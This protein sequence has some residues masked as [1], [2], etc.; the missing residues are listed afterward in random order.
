MS[1]FISN[2]RQESQGYWK[3]Y[4][5]VRVYGILKTLELEHLLFL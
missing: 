5:L 3:F 2:E 1:K 4:L